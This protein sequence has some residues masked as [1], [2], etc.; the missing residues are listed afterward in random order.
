MTKANRKIWPFLVLLVFSGRILAGEISEPG[1]PAA[2]SQSLNAQGVIEP[3]NTSAL[4]AED[5]CNQVP[6]QNK[7]PE[8]VQSGVMVSYKEMDFTRLLKGKMLLVHVLF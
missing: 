7:L 1:E 2:E 3:S 5:K 8:K 6:S 4:I